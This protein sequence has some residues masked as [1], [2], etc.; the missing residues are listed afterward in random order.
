[1]GAYR[2]QFS[3]DFLDELGEIFREEGREVHF[4]RVFPPPPDGGPM[5]ECLFK[6]A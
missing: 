6:G 5:E 1:V 2:S 3:P 4:R